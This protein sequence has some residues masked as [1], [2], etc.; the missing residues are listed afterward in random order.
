MP[1]DYYDDGP[2]ADQT[3]AQ[4]SHDMEKK[5]P[6]DSGKTALIPSSLCPG[7]EVGDSIA[8]E[9]VGVN[10]SEY[11]VRYSHDEADDDEGEPHDEPSMS[12]AAKENSSGMDSMMD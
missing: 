4:G 12:N 7:L 8:L 6:D 9:V 1:T 10:E 11:E 2:A 5:D 3:E